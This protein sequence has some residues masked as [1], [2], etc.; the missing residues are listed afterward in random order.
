MFGLFKNK[1]RKSIE[2]KIPEVVLGEISLEVSMFM[3]WHEDTYKEMIQ[4][5]DVSKIVKSIFDRESLEYGEDDAL[6]VETLAF[7]SDLDQIDRLRAETHF[8]EQVDVFCKS[9]GWTK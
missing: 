8:D 4:P 6:A 2:F 7:A 3:R 1:K 9:I 5:E